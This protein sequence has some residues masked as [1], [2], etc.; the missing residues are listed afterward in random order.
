MSP[1]LGSAALRVWLD[2]T[3]IAIPAAAVREIVRAVSMAPLAGAPSVVEGAINWHGRIV[4]VV[5]LRTR[6][7]LGERPLAPD[8]FLVLIETAGRLVAVRVDDVD[9]I[10]ELPTASIAASESLA[11]SLPHLRGVAASDDG[12]LLVVDVDAFLTTD[13]HAALTAAGVTE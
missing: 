12:A 13:E 8:Q 1:S 4:P 10:A 6:L 9:D 2:A 5:A 3:S 11:L 7:A